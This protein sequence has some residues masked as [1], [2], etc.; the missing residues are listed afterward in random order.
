M[1][2]LAD[3]FLIHVIFKN[4]PYTSIITSLLA[5]K[6]CW[7]SFLGLSSL[8]YVLTLTFV[9]VFTCVTIKLH[10][11]RFSSISVRLLLN[12]TCTVL[13]S[14]D[15]NSILRRYKNKYIYTFP[16]CHITIAKTITVL[17]KYFLTCA[18]KKNI[19]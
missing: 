14:L 6:V 2:L 19:K 17:I 5:A 8:L 3:L 4:Q 11:L 15:K 7:K 9:Y 12:K 10:F 18:N 1:K 13:I 16:S